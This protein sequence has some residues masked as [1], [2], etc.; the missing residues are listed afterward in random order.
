MRRR[1]T[2]GG[3]PCF[4]GSFSLQEERRKLLVFQRLL[5]V[6]HLSCKACAASQRDRRDLEKMFVVSATAH[7]AK[8]MLAA[9]EAQRVPI[10]KKLSL[11]LGSRQENAPLPAPQRY[12]GPAS[13]TEYVILMDLNVWL[14]SRTHELSRV[15]EALLV[16]RM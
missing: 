14:K 1:I 5:L 11:S 13:P 6:S 15:T 9:N 8:G 16:G 12:P 4:C 7:L 3:S 2:S 10:A